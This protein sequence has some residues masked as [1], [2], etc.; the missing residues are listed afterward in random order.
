M[1][2]TFQNVYNNFTVKITVENT[3]NTIVYYVAGKVHMYM[4]H[5]D[6]L[7]NIAKM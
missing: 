2:L 4:Y 5:Q 6:I 3:Y 1:L 7:V